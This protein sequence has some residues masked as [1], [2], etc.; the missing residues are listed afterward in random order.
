M[1]K[2][3]IKNKILLGIGLTALSAGSYYFYKKFTT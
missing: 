1:K 2:G 3:S